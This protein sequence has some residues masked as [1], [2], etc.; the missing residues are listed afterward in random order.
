M[1]KNKLKHMVAALNVATFFLVSVLSFTGCE[2]SVVDA[3]RIVIW[4]SCSEFAQY[5]ELFNKTHKDTKAIIV[6]KTN[7]AESLPPAKD[8]VIPDIVVGSWL[9][10]DSTEKYFK[11]LDYLFDRKQVST[12]MF[13]PQLVEAGV[14]KHR[15]VLLPVSFNLPAIIFDENNKE[16]IPDSYTLTL[17]QIHTTSDSYNKRKP[18]G[19]FSRI[20]FTPLSDDDFLYLVTKLQGVNFRQEKGS[21]V[22]NQNE[23]N[24]TTDYIKNWIASEDSTPQEQVDF[25]FKYLFMPSYRQVASERTL[26]AYTTSDLLF[27]EAK[28]QDI[29]VD[30]RWICNGEI[31]PIEDDFTM[32]GIFKDCKNQVGASE[33]IS[34]FFQSETQQEIIERKNRLNLET[35]LFGISGGFSA[36]KDV[37]EHVLPLYYTK[38]LSNLPPAHMISVSQKLPSRWDSYKSLVVTPYLNETIS[39]NSQKTVAEYEKEWRKKVFD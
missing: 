26:F 13:Y 37:T 20:G 29:N 22:W 17:E 2:Q 10:T 4:T 34:W 8:E 6:Y 1:I 33:F 39:L 9:R 38:L 11:S 30:Y 19:S 31:I 21:I 5:V 28:K 12:T 24:K 36:V 25:A 3:D 18:S 14:Y 35:E 27:K 32:M 15:Q 7:P 16:L 23:L